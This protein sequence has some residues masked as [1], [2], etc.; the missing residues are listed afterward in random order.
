MQ[1]NK[2]KI[3]LLLS[4]L[5]VYCIHTTKMTLFYI[6]TSFLQEE[7]KEL[8]FFTNEYDALRN[9][10]NVEYGIL[11]QLIQIDNKLICLYKI[12]IQNGKIMTI[13]WI[14]E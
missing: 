1:D 3:Q 8:M 6:L 2:F 14:E 7:W 5:Y 11:E 12:H 4:F 10:K 13:D 9:I